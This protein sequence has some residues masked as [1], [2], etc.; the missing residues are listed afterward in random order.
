M[1]HTMRRY[2]NSSL[3]GMEKTF[4]TKAQR[5]GHFVSTSSFLNSYF[6]KTAF[7]HFGLP[8]LLLQECS[9]LVNSKK[10][11]EERKYPDYMLENKTKQ[12]F[13]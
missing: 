1:A 7:P 8:L 10:G 2:G 5:P 13:F 4:V 9:R 3:P 12:N 11:E 6:V